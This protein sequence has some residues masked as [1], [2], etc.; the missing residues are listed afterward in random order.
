MPSQSTQFITIVTFGR[1]GSTALQAAL[2]THPDVI[3]RGENYNA[4]S[5][6]WHYWDSLTD[7]ASRHHSGKST[8]PWFGTA[9][10]D[11][12]TALESLHEHALTTVL[13]PKATTRWSGFK[14]VRYERAYFPH[15]AMLISYLVFLQELFPGLRYLINTRNPESAA[16]SGWWQHHPDARSAL[17]QTNEQLREAG[18]ALTRMLGSHRIQLID[19]E[20][21]KS[22]SSLVFNA[23][24]KLEF[25]PQL[26]IVQSALGNYLSH[27]QQRKEGL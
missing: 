5:G 17:A 7:S 27:G 20:D 19:Y 21:W 22:D 14:E 24:E 3:V 9:R 12:R 1:S 26:E 23:L 10:L 16:M 2:N 8:H 15:S 25:E 11:P 13:R 4:F 6:L 18:T